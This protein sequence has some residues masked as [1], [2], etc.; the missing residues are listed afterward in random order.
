MTMQSGMHITP[1]IDLLRRDEDGN[2]NLLNF[3]RAY[4]VSDYG[5]VGDSVFIKGESNEMW[6][7]ISS[8]SRDDLERLGEKYLSETIYF[9]AIE[10][11]MVPVLADGRE[12]RGQI[13]MIQYLL[14]E[15]VRLPEPTLQFAPLTVADA[16]YVYENSIYRK[17][18]SLDYVQ[19]R[20]ARG[21]SAALRLQGQLI[22]WAITHDDGA[23]G[24][25]HVLPEHRRKGYGTQTTLSLARRSRDRGKKPFAYI[26]EDNVRAIQ[27]V[28]ALGF[29]EQKRVCWLTLH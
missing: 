12:I 13:C 9:A 4:P 21:I 29:V 22:A 7:Y 24:F 5:R 18:F 2:I 17:Y 3:I 11:W 14:P 26:E 16:E 27:L 15:E 25:L 8:D 20:I 6:T 19:D 23:L 28:R 1:I 10:D